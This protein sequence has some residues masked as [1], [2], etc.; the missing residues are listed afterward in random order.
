MNNQKVVIGF[1]GGLPSKDNLDNFNHWC[2]FLNSNSIFKNNI[3]IVVHPLKLSI[4][5]TLISEFKECANFDDIYVVNEKHHIKTKWGAGS[6]TF[7]T[8]LM[9]QYC[10]EQK[11]NIKKFVLVSNTDSPLI[12]LDKMVSELL[13]SNKSYIYGSVRDEN[14][15]KN[16]GNL[17]FFNQTKLFLMNNEYY[18]LYYSQ[19]MILDIQHIKIF[20]LNDI[21]NTWIKEGDIL[22]I[23]TNTNDPKLNKLEE[24]FLFFSK[25]YDG[26]RYFGTTI[27]YG[28]SIEE[29]F[30]G[31]IIMKYIIDNTDKD[32]IQNTNVITNIKQN[33][34]IILKETFIKN[35]EEI[36]TQIRE[37]YENIKTNIELNYNIAPTIVNK[38]NCSK[39][40]NGYFY[41][42]SIPFFDKEVNFIQSSFCDWSIISINPHNILRGFNIRPVN[43]NNTTETNIKWLHFNI[44]KFL[45]I[46]NPLDA[47]NIL[48]EYDGD[49]FKYNIPDPIHPLKPLT[50]IDTTIIFNFD[51]VVSPIIPSAWHPCDY[52]SWSLK[53]MVNAYILM[54]Y[55]KKSFLFM[56]QHN[57]IYNFN[58]AYNYYI[59]EL[60]KN[61]ITIEIHEIKGKYYSLPKLN[62]I[63]N[64][65]EHTYI[66]MI[67]LEQL[68]SAKAQGSFFIRKCMNGS[69]ISKFSDMLLNGKYFNI[70]N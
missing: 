42:T 9:M 23:N 27:Y 67:T 33:I 41:N 63:K 22:K 13:S 38:N 65:N 39:I 60:F 57:D 20:F 62:T 18:D 52:G 45:N 36:S 15:V 51:C 8:L 29:V 48:I 66:T 26:F 43:L 10:F 58:K 37:S 35:I 34:K 55:L 16:E 64:Y 5:D 61:N 12:S 19:W 17:G 69:N 1:L 56:E 70:K 11:I 28:Y 6:L 50:L 21:I 31:N 46:E 14:K 4:D 30:F 25:P 54:T 3:C 68:I 47:L 7:A 40:Y 44:K 2:S 49:L 32:E 24:L 59:S 53:E